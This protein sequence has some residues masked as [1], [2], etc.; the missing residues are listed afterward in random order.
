[1]H[2]LAGEISCSQTVKGNAQDLINLVTMRIDQALERWD[3][4]KMGIPDFALES[5]GKY[6]RISD[7]LV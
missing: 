1:M 2:G 4:D 7:R 5:A 3:A 6:V